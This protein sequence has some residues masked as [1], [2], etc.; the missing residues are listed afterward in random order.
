MEVFMPG[1]RDNSAHKRESVPVIDIDASTPEE[2]AEKAELVGTTRANLG[3]F[4]R[5]YIG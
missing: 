4:T 2:M 1:L 5:S 3:I